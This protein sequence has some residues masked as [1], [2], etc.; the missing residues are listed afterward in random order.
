MEYTWHITNKSCGL[1]CIYDKLKIGCGS[2]QDISIKSIIIEVYLGKIL[3]SNYFNNSNSNL[4]FSLDLF[5]NNIKPDLKKKVLKINL[6][7]LTFITTS[8]FKLKK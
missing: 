7:F 3:V 5:C 8:K 4:I 1:S 6:F 2:A